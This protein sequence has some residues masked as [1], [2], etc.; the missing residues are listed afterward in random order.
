MTSGHVAVIDIGKTNAKLALVD[1]ADLSEIAVVKQPNTVIP[2]PPYPHFDVEG[3]W[4]F[5]LE[6]LAHFQIGY[7][8]DAIVVTTHGAAAALINKAG[9]LAAPIIDYEFTGPESLAAEYD[10]LRAPFSETGSPRLAMGL[11]VGAQIHYQFE[12]LPGLRSAV[13]Q[14][15]MYPQYWGLR[16][17]GVGATDV[18]SLGAHTDLWNPFDNRF[19]ALVDRLGIAGIIAQPRSCSD[20]LGP[21]PARNRVAHRAETWHAGLLRDPRFKCIAVAASA[22]QQSAF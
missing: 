10:V 12:T 6:N 22:V 13:Q 16:L 11:N 9:E 5:L 15:V 18:T 8:V 21:I 17:T 7:G 4:T 2:G 14:I 19:S 3:H 1:L 20:V